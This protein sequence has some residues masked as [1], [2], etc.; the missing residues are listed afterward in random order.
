MIS[1]RPRVVTSRDV[2][3]HALGH[4]THQLGMIH[5]APAVAL[6]RPAVSEVAAEV[7][8]GAGT[9]SIPT[10][11]RPIARVLKKGDAELP[12]KTRC[13]RAVLRRHL[14]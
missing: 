4:L 5:R 11:K 8:I 12:E 6:L 9:A 7:R 13:D 1:P 2:A 14:G 3:S 10:Q